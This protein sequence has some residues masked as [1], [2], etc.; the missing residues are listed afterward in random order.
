MNE[1]QESFKSPDGIFSTRDLKLAATLMTLRFPLMGIDY[2][3]EGVKTRPIGYFKFERSPALEDAKRKYMQLMISV[4]P[5]TYDQMKDTLKAE[6]M[7]VKM[8]PHTG[9]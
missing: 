7:N 2:Q 1:S 5:Q 8:N 3:I 6:V 9:F 4:V